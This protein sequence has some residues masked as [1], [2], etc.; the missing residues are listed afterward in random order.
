MWS[1]STRLIQCL[2]GSHLWLWSCGYYRTF[3]TKRSWCK[4]SCKTVNCLR[5]KIEPKWWK[6]ELQVSASFAYCRG[7]RL[8]RNTFFGKTEGCHFG[9]KVYLKI[10]G[11]MRNVDIVDA[12]MRHVYFKHVAHFCISFRLNLHCRIDFSRFLLTR[13]KCC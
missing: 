7:R 9:L 6:R 4:I 11:R 3:S 12:I 2:F 1:Y 10:S 13:S 8:G 5:T